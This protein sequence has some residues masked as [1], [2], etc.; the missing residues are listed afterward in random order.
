MPRYFCTITCACILFGTAASAPACLND[1]ET[2]ALE[3][4][5]RSRYQSPANPGSDPGSASDPDIS[6][7]PTHS[8][9]NPGALATSATGLGLIAGSILITHRKLHS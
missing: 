1:R 9:W 2:D 6:Q 4:Q 5:F 8:E 3:R 7:L